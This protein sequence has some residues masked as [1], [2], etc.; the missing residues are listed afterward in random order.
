MT[1]I[2]KRFDKLGADGKPS[3]LGIMGGTFDPIHNGH[4][5]IAEEVREQL[6]L[7]AVLFVPTGNPVFKRDQKVTD[8][9]VRLARVRR[10]VAGNPHFDVSSIEV[11]R[12]GSTYTVDTLR[13]LRA[14]Y[15]ENVEFYFIVG[16]DT[17]ATVAKWRS[18]AEVAD[19]FRDANGRWD[20]A[21]EIQNI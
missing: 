13:E 21:Q 2:S 3:R 17:A 16:S 12:P 14:H 9:Q 20:V 18:C 19:N 1:I 10:A 6:G 7:D 15:P 11:E 4:L 8:A 5:R